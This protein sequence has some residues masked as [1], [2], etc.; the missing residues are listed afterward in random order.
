MQQSI[1]MG[2]RMNQRGITQEMV[3]FTLEYGDVKGDRWVM[4]RK[5]IDKTITDLE[6]QLRTA[7][8]FRDKG[9]IVVVA[10]HDALIT[11]YN[12]DS[13]RCHY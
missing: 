4:N 13:K 9:G 2:K 5:N 1:H 7:K 6:L 11:T 12:F 8:K 3:N 10:D